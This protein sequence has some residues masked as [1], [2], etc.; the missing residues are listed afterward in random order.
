MFP[1]S[2]QL[3][4][5]PFSP[6]MPIAP[7][8]WCSPICLAHLGELH[9]AAPDASDVPRTIFQRLTRARRWLDFGEGGFHPKAPPTTL[10]P[11]TPL[12]PTMEFLPAVR[13]IPQPPP[14]RGG[15]SPPLRAPPNTPRGHFPPPPP[16][17]RPHV[18]LVAG[19]LPPP[20]PKGLPPLRKRRA[21]G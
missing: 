13:L 12:D 21:R 10:I 2:R 8:P 15:I 1:R 20:P 9:A 6:A 3:S 7:C 11:R 19:Q 14:T 18:V 17:P 4:A 16:P 5:S